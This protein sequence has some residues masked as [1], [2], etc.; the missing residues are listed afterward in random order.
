VDVS[1]LE[2][3]DPATVEMKVAGFG[4]VAA[5]YDPAAGKITWLTQESLRSNECQVFVT[6]KRKSEPKPDLVSWRF[7]IDLVAHYLPDEPEKLEKATVVEE[8]ALPQPAVVPE[9]PPSG[10]R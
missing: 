1:K 7:F 2:G 4:K 6:F 3:I 9:T 8:G 5:Q 10:E